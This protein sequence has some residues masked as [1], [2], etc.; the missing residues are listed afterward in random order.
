[1]IT[2]W[3]DCVCLKGQFEEWHKLDYLMGYCVHCGVNQLVICFYECF[4][5]GSW[6]VACR[7]FEQDI[8]GVTYE[9]RPKKSGGLVARWMNVFPI[10]KVKDITSI[11]SKWEQF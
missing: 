1:M 8:I 10:A 7:C 6:E 3:E 11:V 5:G 2:L 4:V 9:S